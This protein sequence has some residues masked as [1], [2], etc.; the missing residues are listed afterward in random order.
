MGFVSSHRKKVYTLDTLAHYA[1]HSESQYY[2]YF[3]TDHD[4]YTH[5]P[6]KKVIDAYQSRPARL[7][8]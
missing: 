5:S 2:S 4:W 1:A 8:R 7:K 3:E 6:K